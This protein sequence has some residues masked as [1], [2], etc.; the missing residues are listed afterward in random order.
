MA[1]Q[2]DIGVGEVHSSGAL[3]LPK[4]KMTAA[5]R[6]LEKARVRAEQRKKRKAKPAAAMASGKSIRIRMASA[7][8]SHTTI[9]QRFSALPDG[10]PAFYSDTTG[11]L[12]TYVRIDKD[13][14]LGEADQ[15]NRV[16]VNVARVGAWAGHPQGA[17]RMSKETFD[18]L[19]R[20]FH[21]SGV[22]R[23]QWDFNHCSAMAP[24][25]GNV[26]AIGTPAQGW[27][28]GLK[29]DGV[30]LY[31][32]TEWQP[33]AKSYIEN[34]QYDSA[35]VVINWKTKDRVTGAE[36]GPTLRSIAL[37]NEAFITGLQPLAADANG[38]ATGVNRGFM[39]L[40]E[41]D[42][43]A[44]EQHALGCGKYACHSFGAMLPRLKQTFGLHE[45]A[46]VDQ[47]QGALEMY[48]SHLDAL[49]GNGMGEHEGVDL[50]GYSMPMREMVNAHAGMDWYAILDIIDELIDAYLDQHGLPDFEESHGPIPGADSMNSAQSPAATAASVTGADM[51][52]PVAPEAVVAPAEPVAVVET[53]A[54]AEVAAPAETTA[55]SATVATEVDPQV[56]VLALQNAALMAEKTQ[57]Q[58]ELDR[59]KA[60]AGVAETSALA[61]TVDAAIATYK[62]TRGLSEELRPHLMSMLKTDPAGFAL[63]YP[64]V[65]LD[66]RHLLLNLTGGGAS[67]PAAPGTRT[68]EDVATDVVALAAVPAANDETQSVALSL[69][70]IMDSLKTA[71]P[72]LTHDQRL[73]LADKMISKARRA[74]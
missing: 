52:N 44:T 23:I 57:M 60:I 63:M 19:E 9:H 21:N 34:D 72:N 58:S 49:E 1:Q 65:D 31:A 24:T 38:G 66:K 51:A 27:V 43:K 42:T 68:A 39:Q 16:W 12:L 18:A 61:V 69:S 50:G 3:A 22:R 48:R 54:P 71:H 8:G 59:L 29:N 36:I 7:D 40:Q 41:V 20:N 74:Q 13:S 14:A 33:L 17:F 46:T 35:S 10:S 64:P 67:N 11:Q 26:P 55:A 32:L 4:T 6:R 73:S 37:T 70:G 2:L 53:V 25:S 62:D 45:L 5:Q 47:V 15:D 28:Y 56:A 30:N